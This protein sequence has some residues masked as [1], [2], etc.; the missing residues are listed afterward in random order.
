MK[1][2]WDPVKLRCCWGDVPDPGDVLEMRTGRRYQVLRVRGRTM[3]CIVL[4]TTHKLTRGTRV[5]SW[6]WAPRSR[7]SI[8]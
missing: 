1:Q 8:R 3:H 5:L 6:R 7:R 4:P 2:A